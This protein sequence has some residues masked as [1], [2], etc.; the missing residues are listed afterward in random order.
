M[1]TSRRPFYWVLAGTAVVIIANLVVL[2]WLYYFGQVSPNVHFEELTPP[3]VTEVCPGDTLDYEFVIVTNRAATIDL[4]T[5]FRPDG[6]RRSSVVRLQQFEFDA[7]VR[8]RLARQHVIPPLY[9]DPASGTGI[10]WTPG[11]Y[12]QRTVV[13]VEGRGSGS[14]S[15][16]VWFVIPERCFA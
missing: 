5:S 3:V 12:W 11:K 8:F 2:A 15:I 4:G 1:S 10:P 6:S 7:A 9:D 16:E 13:S 14:D